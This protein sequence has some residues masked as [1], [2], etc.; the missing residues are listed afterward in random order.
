MK[1]FTSQMSGCHLTIN[2]ELRGHIKQ[3]VRR[4]APRHQR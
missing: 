4:E 3:M 1:L 2:V